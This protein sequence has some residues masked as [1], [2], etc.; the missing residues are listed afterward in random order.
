MKVKI[1]IACHKPC[2]IRHDD[3]YTPIHVGFVNSKFKKEM[4]WMQMMQ[5]AKI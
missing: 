4:K 5:L 1:F 2:E 3:V